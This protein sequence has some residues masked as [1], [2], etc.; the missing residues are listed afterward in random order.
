MLRSALLPTMRA[1]FPPS[2]RV[3]LFKFV[4]PDAFWIRCPTSV[5]PVKVTLLM[6]GCSEMAAPAVGP[7]PVI[8]L[9]TPAEKKTIYLFY[10]GDIVQFI[11]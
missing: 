3:T 5:D 11:C 9:I 6:S 4:S 10:H 7:N 8:M 2:S 1:L